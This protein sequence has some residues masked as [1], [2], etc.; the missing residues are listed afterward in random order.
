MC[1]SFQ[2]S[3]LGMLR[4]IN[5]FCLELLQCR[6]PQRNLLRPFENFLSGSFVNWPNR[7][8]LA[9]ARDSSVISAAFCWPTKAN[10]ESVIRHK[11]SE[12]GLWAFSFCQAVWQCFLARAVHCQVTYFDMCWLFPLSVACRWFGACAEPHGDFVEEGWRKLLD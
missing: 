7:F 12:K 3:S 6:M 10:A 11:L 1:S 2:G 9:Q 5:F 4:M 8:S